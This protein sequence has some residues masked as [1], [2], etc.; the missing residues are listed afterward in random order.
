MPLKPARRMLIIAYEPSSAGQVWVKCV[1]V[2]APPPPN[3]KSMPLLS[4]YSYPLSHYALLNKWLLAPSPQPPTAIWACPH[5]I[6]RT[7]VWPP[8]RWKPPAWHHPVPLFFFFFSPP[9]CA[10]CAEKR[11]A[12]RDCSLFINL[13]SATGWG[14][15]QARQRRLFFLVSFFFFFQHVG[16]EMRRK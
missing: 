10:A 13:S 2:W 6:E 14:C 4:V 8:A 5:V 9:P 12:G 1:F 11:P 16:N 7:L 3:P 15:R